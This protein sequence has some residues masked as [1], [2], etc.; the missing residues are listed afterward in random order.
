MQEALAENHSVLM[1]A[2]F[3]QM[4]ADEDV[5]R[6]QRLR[7]RDRPAEGFEI[8]EMAGKAAGDEIEN[9]ARDRIG[10]EARRRL[11]AEAL[12]R[13]LAV[14]GVEVPAPADGLVA[15][16]EHA[17]RPPHLAIEELHPQPR[18]ALR[19]AREIGPCREESPV[20]AQLRPRLAQ[21]RLDA[22]F[23]G[24]GDDDPPCAMALFR[25]RDLAR[26]G[27]GV[28][29]IV[30]RDIIDPHALP[31]KLRR[32]MTHRGKHERDLLL[33]VRNVNRLLR[34]LRH[35]HDV[36]GSEVGKG[37]NVARELVAEH[38]AQGR[39]GPLTAPARRRI[40]GRFGA[41]AKVWRGAGQAPKPPL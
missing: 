30:E 35:Q 41:V 13:R 27:A 32:E 23:A 14:L 9:L 20:L 2:E 29:G 4:V 26:E 34:D 40:A 19:P 12:G 39:H 18:A 8:A 15:V 25:P 22:I 28:F 38:E 16:H 3:R 24:L 36:A 17:V 11:R 1:V 33:V 10:G 5:E 7:P 6:L 37:G 31:A 21:R